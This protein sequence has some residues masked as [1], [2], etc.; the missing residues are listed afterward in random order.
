[1]GEK[2]SNLVGR[3]HLAKEAIREKWA[4]TKE[5]GGF[6]HRVGTKVDQVREDVIRQINHGDQT[7]DHLYR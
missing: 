5:E 2:Y 4:S 6:T 7:Y 1:M 3:F